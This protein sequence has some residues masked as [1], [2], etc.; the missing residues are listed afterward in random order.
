VNREDQQ[1][2]IALI[3]SAR[4][5]TPP[6][7]AA[8]ESNRVQGKCPACGRS[9]LLLGSG[10]YVTCGRLECSNPTAATDALEGG[11]DGVRALVEAFLRQHG[12]Q[13]GSG[14]W[15]EHWIDHEGPTAL[16]LETALV[17]ELARKEQR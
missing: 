13:R 5:P 10:G 2:A 16:F 8:V 17:V 6:L 14:R 11:R 3:E 4:V 12:W 1:R 7:P 15:S 9:S